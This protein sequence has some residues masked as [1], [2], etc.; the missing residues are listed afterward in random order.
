MSDLKNYIVEYTGNILAPDGGEV[1][2]EMVI[3]VLAK[4]FPEIVLMMAEENW[5]RGYEQGLE[6]LKHFESE[7]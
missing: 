4:E 7:E 3:E 1:T 6:D 2:A 5:V